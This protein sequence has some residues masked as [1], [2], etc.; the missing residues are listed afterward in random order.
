A[1][2]PGA[3]AAGGRRPRP[4]PRLPPRRRGPAG[5]RGAAGGACEAV[6]AHLDGGDSGYADSIPHDFRL[7]EVEGDG[8]LLGVARL[9][10]RLVPHSLPNFT[11]AMYGPADHIAP[12]DDSVREQY[13]WQ[14][15]VELAKNYST[16]SQKCDQFGLSP[17]AGSRAFRRD[18]AAVYYLTDDWPEDIGGLFV[19]LES[20]EKI[21][22][23]FNTLLVFSV[24][25]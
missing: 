25:R 8:V 19:D 5:P 6:G 23:E 13:T 24:P 18:T 1:A 14:E 22:P 21:K 3:L 15:V 4:D 12:H 20:G 16:S 10:W 9:L 11:A 17:W 7:L 2:R